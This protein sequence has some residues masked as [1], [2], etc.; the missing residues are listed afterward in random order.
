MA[1]FRAQILLDE[2]QH[3]ELE[4]LARESGR[5]MSDLVRGIMAD[6]LARASQEEAVRDSLTAVD[7]LSEL[8]QQIERKHGCLPTSFLDDLREER[9]LEVLP[10]QEGALRW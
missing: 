5:S 3:D 2:T 7:Q 1:L 10:P 8:R 4:R 6:Y 9:D